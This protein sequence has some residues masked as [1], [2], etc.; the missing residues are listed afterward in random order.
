M[1]GCTALVL[2][3]IRYLSS[4]GMTVDVFSER[5]DTAAI[6]AA[7]GRVIRLRRRPGPRYWARRSFAR[8]VADRTSGA[9][10]QMVIGHGDLLEQDCL[11]VHNPVEWEREL[12]G[13][14]GRKSIDSLDRFHRLM[15]SRGRYRLLIANSNLV[16]RDLEQR[17]DLD[18]QCIHIAYPGYDPTRF[19]IDHRDVLRPL[20]RKEL[21]IGDCFLIGFVTSGNFPMRGADILVDTIARLSPSLQRDVR[22][23]VV[24]SAGNL[25]LMNRLFESRNL[26][27]LMMGRGKIADVERYYHALDLMLHPARLE[28]FGLVVLESI[29][30]G[31]PLLTSRRVGASELL[32]GHG[33]IDSPDAGQFAESLA[34]L[35][36]DPEALERLIDQQ[37]KAVLQ[38]TWQAYAEDC[39][40]IWR[41]T[42]LMPA[43]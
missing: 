42:G 24:G 31:T 29:G 16:A 18:P 19:S 10:Y 11:F 4:V 28:P 7:G 33:V 22:V 41:G 6:E 38:R 5:P 34:T 36:A 39:A 20:V 27:D 37:R 15:Y 30:C 9:G 17:Y 1:S 3:Q 14:G 32:S 12:A 40:A 2:Q 23:L 25:S 8:R 43:P 26:R 13:R 21:A 35:I